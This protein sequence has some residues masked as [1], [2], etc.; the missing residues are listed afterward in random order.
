VAAG[1]ANPLHDH[2]RNA[3]AGAEACPSSQVRLDRFVYDGPGSTA[4]KVLFEATKGTFRFFSGNSPHDAYQVTT[5]QA[6]IGVRGTVYDVEIGPGR[7]R[8]VLQRGAVHVCVRNTRL[9]KDLTEIGS[10]A[11]VSTKGISG[12]LPPA[13]KTWD[14]GDLCGQVLALLCERTT[15]AGRDLSAAKTRT[16]LAALP[17]RAVPKRRA[18]TKTARR[19]VRRRHAAGSAYGDD[20]PTVLTAPPPVV[21]LVPFLGG[22]YGGFR[23]G[24][25]GRGGRDLP[26]PQR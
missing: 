22:G 26:Q 19:P 5:P 16:Q 11:V 7:T 6:T 21:P 18:P 14:F 3:G 1:Q 25:G 13:R 24:F 4:K 8:V 10:S 23:G 2:P 9:C 20:V 12:P 15:I 17:R